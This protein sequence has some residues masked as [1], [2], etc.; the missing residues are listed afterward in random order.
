MIPIFRTGKLLRGSRS[1]KGIVACSFQRQLK[2]HKTLKETV[3]V[4]PAFELH[5]SF[6]RTPVYFT[7]NMV[8]V[9]SHSMHKFLRLK[10][11]FLEGVNFYWTSQDVRIYL[12]IETFWQRF[13]F[14]YPI[15]N[16]HC[17]GNMQFLLRCKI[18]NCRY[19]M[20]YVVLIAFEIC[21]IDFFLLNVQNG[22]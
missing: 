20:K 15:C 9:S 7:S 11:S 21:I 13:L 12:F 8:S 10:L 3:E 14:H 17:T 1:E 22:K 6:H 16:F 2:L 19:V 4:F 18:C 5:L